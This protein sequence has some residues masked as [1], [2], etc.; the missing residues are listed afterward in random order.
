M[1]NSLNRG[2][3]MEWDQTKQE[4]IIGGNTQFLR[5]WDAEKEL[6]SA[7][8]PTGADSAVSSIKLDPS[9]LFV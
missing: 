3:I 5:I 8:V 7:D 9:G 2:Y 1:K 6:M 4:F